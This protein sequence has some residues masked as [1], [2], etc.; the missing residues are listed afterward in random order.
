M[1][2]ALCPLARG[3]GNTSVDAKT[4]AVVVDPPG[5]TGPAPDQR[6]VGHLDERG[7]GGGVGRGR[8]E[9]GV[10][11][12]VKHS[13]DI[14]GLR[15]VDEDFTQG[16]ASASVFTLFSGLGEAKQNSPGG[17]LLPFIEVSPDGLSA[18]GESPRHPADVFVRPPGE[19]VIGAP[20]V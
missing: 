3:V 20:L 11:K 13:F 19:H 18:S 4:G 1:A 16:G 12:L 8:H 14:R 9:P 5:E 17:L 2:I 6:L 7:P 15:R 10:G